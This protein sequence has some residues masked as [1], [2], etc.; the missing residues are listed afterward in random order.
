[1]SNNTVAFIQSASYIVA[2]ST[3]YWYTHSHG[4]KFTYVFVINL[5]KDKVLCYKQKIATMMEI[6]HKVLKILSVLLVT[7]TH[8]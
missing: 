2:T 1:M 5:E 4:C 8:S 7:P 3:C 6:H